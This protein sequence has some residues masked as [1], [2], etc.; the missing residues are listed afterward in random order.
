MPIYQPAEDSFLMKEI[1]EKEVPELLKENKNLKFL[2][3]GSGS[4]IQIEALTNLNIKQENITLTD[5]NQEAVINLKK[6]FSKSK[7]I[8]SN[9][10]QNVEDK[11]DLI[12]FNPP[13]LPE[14]PQEP[15]DSKLATTGGEK[16]SEVVNRFLTEAKNHLT[17]KGRI[18]LLTSSLTE[19]ID[20]SG[21]NKRKIGE[22]KLFMEHLFVWEL[23]L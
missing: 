10:F 19:G 1:L 15:E 4:G 9:L 11:F 3:I 17:S 14:D 6:K 23:T 22:K 21:W 18:L 8:N 20:W 2:E 5:I 7:V 12:I 16:G 13:Y